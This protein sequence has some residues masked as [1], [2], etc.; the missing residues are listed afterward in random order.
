ML[1]NCSPIFSCS[2]PTSKSPN[3]CTLSTPFL[4][5]SVVRSWSTSCERKRGKCLGMINFGLNQYYDIY[6][7]EIAVQLSDANIMQE[8]ILLQWFTVLIFWGGQQNPMHKLTL[9]CGTVI[10]L[11]WTIISFTFWHHCPRRVRWKGNQK[12]T[13]K[14]TA[15]VIF[16]RGGLQRSTCSCHKDCHNSWHDIQPIKPIQ[17]YQ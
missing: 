1:S 12:D 7:G 10:N 6:S 11:V 4:L 8:C 3:M 9:S 16:E 5:L 13:F 14:E 15:P 17:A 2:W